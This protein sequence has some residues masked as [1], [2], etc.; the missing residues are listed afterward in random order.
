LNTPTPRV[1][2]A[3]A[4]V[5]ANGRPHFNTRVQEARHRHPSFDTRA[6]AA[7]LAD[8]LDPIATAV[9]ALAPDRTADVVV[10]AYDLA[11]ELVA[12]GL[13]GP[14]AR[15]PAAQRAWIDV[16]PRCPRLLAQHPVDVLGLLGNA[17]LHVAAVAGARL[18]EWLAGMARHVEA[19]QDLAQLRALGQLLAWRAGLAHFREGA[20][21]AAHALPPAL[22]LAAVGAD[23]NEAW[24]V[25]QARLR[26]EPWWDPDTQRREAA[27]A[28]R[29]AGAFAGFGGPFAQPPSVRKAPHGF[30][31]RSG[32][33]HWLLVA[34][35]CG[36]VLL[37]ATAAEFDA[38]PAPAA[39]ARARLHG[40]QLMIKARPYELDLPA[41]A[42]VLVE[43]GPTA[44]LTSP[45]THAIRLWPLP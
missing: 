35:A 39:P 6:F 23:A 38:A 11:L 45:Y 40:T 34:D 1:S 41:E 5:L 27:E 15:N 32:D 19:V 30:W 26:E 7:F 36:A 29:E 10:A 2:Q 22:A 42:L 31:V 37:P 21:A 16:A 18:D 3:L 44:A 14:A 9:A 12:Q 33:R 25:V 20:L 17:A 28:G 4:T 8:A 43:S 24:G 13:G